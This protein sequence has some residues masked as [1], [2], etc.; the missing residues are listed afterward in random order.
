MR[1]VSRGCMSS[2]P[3]SSFLLLLSS[4][5]ILTILCLRQG[6]PCFVAHF[7][8]KVRWFDRESLESFLI[9]PIYPLHT[10]CHGCAAKGYRVLNALS[11]YVGFCAMV[12]H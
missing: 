2:S 5:C 8:S 11:F 7:C 9:V 3:W 10:L 12:S 4:P 1:R 6:L